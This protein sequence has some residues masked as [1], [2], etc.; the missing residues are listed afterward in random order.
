LTAG[1]ILNYTLT[2]SGTNPVL[3]LNFENFSRVGAGLYYSKVL[4]TDSLR[5]TFIITTNI[6]Q[7]ATLN[8]FLLWEII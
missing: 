1:I 5:K 2:D 3:S 4:I 6:M 7:E 8:C